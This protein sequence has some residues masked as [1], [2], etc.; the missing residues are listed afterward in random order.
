MWKI[1]EAQLRR[2]EK[3]GKLLDAY[4][5]IL[6]SKLKE[7]L[8]PAGTRERQKQIYDFITSEFNSFHGTSQ[9]GTF[10]SVLRKA[11]SCVKKAADCVLKAENVISAAAQ[12][13]LPASIACAG[14]MLVVSLCIQAGSQRDVLFKGLD[15]IPD[16]IYDL[17]EHEKL[18]W[19]DT[20]EPVFKRSMTNLCS[21]ILEFL[22]RAACHLQKHP[23]TRILKD[24]FNQGE[25][26]VLLAAIKNAEAR[27][28]NHSTVSGWKD[29]R[30]IREAQEKDQL[31]QRTATLSKATAARNEKIT[32][33]LKKIHE[34]A[35]PDGDSYEFSKDRV[36]PPEEGTCKW[37]INHDKFKAWESSGNP[38]S[39]FLL[40]TAYPGCGKSVL[41]KHL[42]DT[43]LSQS[44]DRTVCYFFFKDDFEHQKSA[45]GA[46]CTLLHQLLVMSESKGCTLLA[47]SALRRLETMGNE[48]FFGSVCSLWKTFTE[49]ALH[50]D[51]GEVVCVLDALDECRTKDRNEIIRAINEFYRTPRN[52]ESSSLKFFLTSRPYGNIIQSQFYV[53]G[54]RLPEIRLAGEEDDVAN[55]I[56]AEIKIVVNKRID[57]IC[58]TFHLSKRMTELMKTNLGNTPG[59]TYLWITLVFDDLLKKTSGIN[60][61]YIESFA[62]NPP[63]DVDDTYE[64][65]LNRSKTQSPGNQ[66]LKRTR[67]ILQ[68]VVAARRPLTLQEMSIALPLTEHEPPYKDLVDEIDTEEGV[69]NTIRDCCGL[70]VI[71][72]DDRL[73]LLHQTV[74]EFLV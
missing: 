60:K 26:D 39:K 11:A 45:V 28:I 47:D 24:M 20:Q 41:S 65:I 17:A 44:K 18:H 23:V 3:K 22:A 70:L 49:A 38:N 25:W 69:W 4:Y 46:L 16:V 53:W 68:M 34:H 64:K 59:R 37:F 13:C 29:V 14:V 54:H 62:K 33:F 61:E 30:M 43:V 36:K 6:K 56:A 74:R 71:R 67:N 51:A 1:A 73:Y 58:N 42:I 57:Q 12:P 55:D 8:E 32:A 48:S 50:T 5:D 72:V 31:A 7:D 35:W 10:S 9:S 21:G 66:D 63:K 40:L 19:A 52:Q 27:L 15:E 2:D